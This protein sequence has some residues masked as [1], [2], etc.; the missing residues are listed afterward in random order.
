VTLLATGSEVSIAVAARNN[1]QSAGVGTRIVS[2]PCWELFE[3]QDDDYRQMILGPGTVRI[4]IEAAVAM[5]WDRYLG[6]D[7]GFVGMTGFGASAPAKEL[8]KHFGIT[9]EAVVELAKANLAERQGR[10]DL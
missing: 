3:E 4:G 10:Q 1:L 7:G 9:A 5:G 8:F 6:L 2:M